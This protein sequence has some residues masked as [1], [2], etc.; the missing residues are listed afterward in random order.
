MNIP[1]VAP[2]TQEIPAPDHGASSAAPS[3]ALW[4]PDG[5]ALWSLLFTPIFGS[6]LHAR[7]WQALGD[8]AMARRMRVWCAVS[9]LMLLVS[10]AL[11]LLTVPYWTLWYLAAAQKQSTSV[12]ARFGKGYVRRAFGPPLLVAVAASTGML[13]LALLAGYAA[14][15][16]GLVQG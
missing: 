8:E 10:M 9:V 6:V 16:L 5:A 13:A 12:K 14:A 2:M 11:P 4:N 3:P 7:N 1:A 15:T